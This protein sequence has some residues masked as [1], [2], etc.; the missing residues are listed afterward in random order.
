MEDQQQHLIELYSQRQN[1]LNQIQ[2]LNEKS[3]QK[4]ELLL[5]VEG[6]I[7]YLRNIGVALPESE[8][9]GELKMEVVEENSEN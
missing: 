5:R 9:D 1:I 7:E 6:A 3:I 4:R 2:E 8:K